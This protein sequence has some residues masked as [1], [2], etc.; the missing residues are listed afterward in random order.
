M[1]YS[2]EIA[3]CDDLVTKCKTTFGYVS[4]NTMFEGDQI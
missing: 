3:E 2:S 1:A 4:H